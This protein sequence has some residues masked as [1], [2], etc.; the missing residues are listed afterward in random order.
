M[1]NLQ[2]RIGRL[3][4]QPGGGY[5]TACN[6]RPSLRV[7]YPEATEEPPLPRCLSCGKEGMTV[8]VVYEPD[9]GLAPC[10]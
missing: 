5:C 2:R 1:I 7:I 6:G 10:G 8:R 3:E 9:L 4:H